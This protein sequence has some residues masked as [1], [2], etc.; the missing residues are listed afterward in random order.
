MIEK[1]SEE[2]TISV[3][4]NV[5]EGVLSYIDYQDTGPGID[6]HILESGALFEPQF[7]MKPN[8]TGIGLAIA[9]EAAT[10]NNLKL[11]ALESTNGAYF[12]LQPIER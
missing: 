3:R 12:R 10:R 9:G 2:K 11:E 1:N 7:S 5:E 8:G 6:S 4:V